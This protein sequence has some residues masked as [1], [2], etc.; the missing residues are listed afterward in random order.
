MPVIDDGSFPLPDFPSY[1]LRVTQMSHAA[2]IEGE[3]RSVYTDGRDTHGLTLPVLQE[4]AADLPA[5][6]AGAEGLVAKRL[7]LSGLRLNWYASLGTGKDAYLYETWLRVGDEDG[8]PLSIGCSVSESVSAWK[9]TVKTCYEAGA[10]EYAW[11][12]CTTVDEGL[13]WCAR[14]LADWLAVSHVSIKWGVLGEG[15]LWHSN[16]DLRVTRSPY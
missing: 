14:T 16:I 6:M 3:P 11:E 4:A 7:G 9:A 1:W 5:A 12:A 13:M 8:F 2:K 15:K 10:T